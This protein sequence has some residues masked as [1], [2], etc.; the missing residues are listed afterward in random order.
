LKTRAEKTKKDFQNETAII[1][2]IRRLLMKVLGK[3]TEKKTEKT[4]EK[5]TREL[6]PR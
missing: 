6:I 3:E 2:P 5:E 4:E 1:G